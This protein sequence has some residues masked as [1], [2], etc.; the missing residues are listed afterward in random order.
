M[1]KYELYPT[2]KYRKDRKRLKKRGLDMTKLDT[3]IEMLANGEELPEKYRDHALVGN[4]KG[5]RDCHI[6]PDWLLIYKIDG[7]RLVLILS[8][9]GSHADLL[10]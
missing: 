2:T 8:Q 10:E 1:H 7:D 6:E 4:L 5:Y 9:T 3:V